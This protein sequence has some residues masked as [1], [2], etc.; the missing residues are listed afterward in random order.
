MASPRKYAILIGIQAY[1]DKQHVRGVNYAK[2]DVA[3][4]RLALL[5]LGYLDENIIVLVNDQATKTTIEQHLDSLRMGL[6]PED[7][8][9]M[10][11]AGLGYSTAGADFLACWDTPY[12]D[13]AGSGIDLEAL[14]DDLRSSVCLN[15]QIYLDC[16]I[17]DAVV[18]PG[19]PSSTSALVL[20]V[21]RIEPDDAEHIACFW[22][23]RPGEKSYSSRTLKHGIWTH[24]LSLALRGEEPG[25]LTKAGPLTAGPLQSHLLSAVQSTVRDTWTDRRKQTPWLAASAGHE[26]LVADLG[27]VLERK[28][29]ETAARS[30][31][32][33][34]VVFSR[35]ERVQIRSL[36]GFAK[37][38]TV[39]KQYT[40]ATQSFVVRVAQ[41]NI[42][43]DIEQMHANI[44]RNLK[45][46][47]KALRVTMP[48]GSQSGSIWTP[49][50]QYSVWVEQLEDEPTEALI[51][52][53]LSEVRSDDIPSDDRFRA[54]FDNLFNTVRLTFA[55]PVDVVEVIDAIE[56]RG[57]EDVSVVYPS[58]HSYCDVSLVGRPGSLRVK[59]DGIELTVPGKQPLQTL[60]DAFTQLMHAVNLTGVDEHI[61]T[62]S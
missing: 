54:L 60:L 13:P 22:S 20:P 1:Q 19:E 41:K 14:F 51:S 42:E 5:G 17:K 46:A 27:D 35:T 11:F 37:P 28:R 6:E 39:P 59:A 31:K 55:K 10:F 62:P 33:R 9:L 52:R 45:Y 2:A 15:I 34:D 38:F 49:D 25:I 26:F 21:A 12:A 32:I 8:F 16:C 29:A 36:A 56:A 50:F 47:R 57:Q 3:A 30:N 43:N 40:S 24:H 18:D 7:A 61:A 53:S 48:E 23:C 44:Q 4:M 58:H